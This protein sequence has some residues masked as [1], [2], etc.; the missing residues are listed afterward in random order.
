MSGVRDT[1]V[2][3]ADLRHAERLTVAD[4]VSWLAHGRS[5]TGIGELGNTHSFDVSREGLLGVGL[6]C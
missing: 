1:R 6:N 4:A 2:D 5:K 3:G